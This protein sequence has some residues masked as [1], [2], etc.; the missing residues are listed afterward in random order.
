MERS[1]SSRGRLTE[2][3]YNAENIYSRNRAHYG[4]DFFCRLHHLF[5]RG[6]TGPG[7]QKEQLEKTSFEKTAGVTGCK[8]NRRVAET[9]HEEKTA[10]NDDIIARPALTNG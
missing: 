2:R 1:A 7:V 9:K 8:K 4:S 10:G 5:C 6:L 3:D